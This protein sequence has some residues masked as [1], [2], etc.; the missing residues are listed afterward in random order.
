MATEENLTCI[1]MP[2][3]GD[4]SAKQFLFMAVDANGRID[5]S[6]AGADAIGVLQDK[7]AAIDRPGQVAVEGV[8]K[9]VCGAAVT[10]GNKVSSDAAGKAIPTSGSGKHVLGT[11]RTTTANSGE[12]VEV[13]L[14]SRFLTP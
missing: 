6:G 8:S 2:A 12:I 14:D 13:V 9:V 7:P 1:S 3:A 11:A 5:I 4:L 10:A